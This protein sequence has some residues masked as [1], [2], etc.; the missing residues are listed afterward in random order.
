MNILDN[1]NGTI[2]INGKDAKSVDI[3]SIEGAISIHLMPEGFVPKVSVPVQITSDADDA[4]PMTYKVKVR[5][6]MTKKGFEF[7][8]KWNNDIPMPLR[9]MIGQIDKETPNMYHMQLHGDIIEE[10]SQN[11][12][13]CG[14]PITNEISKYFGMGPVCGN[15]NYVNPFNSTEELKQAVADYRAKL[16]DIKWSGW[17]PKSAIEEIEEWD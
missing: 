11:C 15:H 10:V 3:N 2:E 13:C 1:W 7:M 9:V 5:A 8:V 4:E 12:M 6:W 14:K 17:I 16:K